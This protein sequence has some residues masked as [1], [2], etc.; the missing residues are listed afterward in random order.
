M[1]VDAKKA[2]GLADIVLE[3]LRE[4]VSDDLLNLGAAGFVVCP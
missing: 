3:H 4:P 1:E 2:G